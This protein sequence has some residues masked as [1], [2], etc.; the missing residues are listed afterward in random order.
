VR[1][2]LLQPLLA[3]VAA[4]VTYGCSLP[5]LLYGC[6]LRQLLLGIP[7]GKSYSYHASLLLGLTGLVPAVLKHAAKLRQQGEEERLR[8]QG[9]VST[10]LRCWRN[11]STAPWR[12]AVHL[13]VK[14][15]SA[16]VRV[17]S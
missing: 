1:L 11:V 4:F 5:H 15:K 9:P 2:V 16:V 3:T 10:Q 17:S 8:K 13:T 14:S 7:H 6:S 12:V